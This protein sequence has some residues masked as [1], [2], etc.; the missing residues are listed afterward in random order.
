MLGMVLDIRV[1]FQTRQGVLGAA[2]DIPQ[3][4]AAG[5]EL[6]GVKFDGSRL[7]FEIA[8]AGAVFEG[9]L[10]PDETISGE[11]RQSGMSGT[12]SLERADPKPVVSATPEP[13]PYQEVEVT[14]ASGDVKFA[15]TLTL[16]PGGVP[17][18]AVILITGSG[19]QDRDE[20]I[21]GFKLFRVIA[22]HLTRH[23]IA[24]LRYDDRGVG[25]STGDVNQAT[26]EDFAGDV[27]SALD[28]L[29]NRPDVDSAQ[30]GLL[31][32]SEG[33]IVAPL[34]A[35]R[36]DGVAFLV[37]MA[38]TALP[39]DVILVEQL[40]LILR[41][42]GAT[43]AHI[44][45]Q[46][47]L[48]EQIIAK[49]RTGEGWDLVESRLRQISLE[50]L[51]GMSAAERAAIADADE[52][53]DAVVRQRLQAA[54]TP[55]FRYFVD[56]DPR[57]ALGQVQVPVLAVFGELDLQ[58][59][60]VPN[61]KALVRTLEQANHRE[62]TTVIVPGANHRFQKAVTGNPTEYAR[63]EPE[64]LPGFLDLITNWILEDVLS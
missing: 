54:Q 52:F 13:V 58:V 49:I 47:Q 42:G 31:G 27:L 46:V 12:F 7:D 1:E 24:V 19:P 14:F 53:A 63:L 16:P 11:M 23:G 64:F 8:A 5:L 9:E 38:G 36:S 61:Q 44:E 41:A 45:Q 10:H 60:A 39:G 3:Q 62:Y 18:P 22:N 2:I 6:A 4:G 48:Q 37:L 56:Y 20:T 28:L 21:F 33:G 55:W 26:T 25:G 30:I 15:G 35:T 50:E 40:K 34:A 32:H 29:Q 17:H 57:L 59:P 51:D 43:D